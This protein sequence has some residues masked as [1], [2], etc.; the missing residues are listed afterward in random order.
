VSRFV[1][2]ALISFIAS[3]QL[4]SPAPSMPGRL[5]ATD[6][7]HRLHL[8][9]TGEGSAPTVALVGGGGGYSLDWELVQP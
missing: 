1:V 6:A 8:W 5:V 9:C 2:I 7:G 3:A 4:E